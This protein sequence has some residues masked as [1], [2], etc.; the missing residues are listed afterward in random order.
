MCPAPLTSYTN[1]V[2]VTTS[3]STPTYAA[4]DQI[5][6]I[7]HIPRV[8]RENGAGSILQS[9]SVVDTGGVNAELDIFFFNKAPGLS[10]TDNS[11]FAMQDSDTFS[12]LGY[13]NVSG[14]DYK[15]YGSGSIACI[16]SPGLLL[17]PI[18]GSQDCFS[19]AVIRT[20]S[21]WTSTLS[22]SL[23]FQYNL[24]QD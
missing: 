4:G 1:L 11:S 21:V 16:K 23:N 24:L 8:G 12:C 13:V 15:S 5:G 9:V 14:T 22:L 19:V 17:T 3:A 6:E 20:T 10:S 2:T 7:Q 18:T